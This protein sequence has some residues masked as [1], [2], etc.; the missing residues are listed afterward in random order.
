MKFLQK[1]ATV[2]LFA[3]VRH[4]VVILRVSELMLQ[5]RRNSARNE[6]GKNRKKCSLIREY[7]F[8]K[9]DFIYE[10]DV[11]AYNSL[12]I[13]SNGKYRPRFIAEK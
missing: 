3:N 12:L 7:I 4:W 6:G 8:V 2:E 1:F 11:C 13:K 9:C 5:S 10:A